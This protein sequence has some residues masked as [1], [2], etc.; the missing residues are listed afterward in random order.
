MRRKQIKSTRVYY[1][2][3]HCTNCLREQNF[4]KYECVTQSTTAR[5]HIKNA[6]QTPAVELSFRPGPQ[7][8]AEMATNFACTRKPENYSN[9]ISCKR[10]RSAISGTHL[11]QIAISASIYEQNARRSWQRMIERFFCS[12]VWRMRSAWHGAHLLLG[13]IGC[14]ASLGKVCQR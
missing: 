8:S 2:I 3:L 7:D 11:S 10:L 5:V 13:L 9:R 4:C 12:L 14:V 6:Q 1:H